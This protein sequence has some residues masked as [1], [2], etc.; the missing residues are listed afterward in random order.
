MRTQIGL[1]SKL[2]GALSIVNINIIAIA[3][4]SSERSI[5]V[6]VKNNVTTVG[7]QAIHRVLFDTNQ[8]IEIFIIGVGGVGSALI[9][10]I[11]RQYHWLK[12]N[13]SI[14]MKV[15]GIANSQGMYINT[16]G[17]NL[18][19]WKTLLQQTKMSCSLKKLL[20]MIK[21]NHLINPVIID[22]TSSVDIA[23]CYIDFLLNG[24]HV[25]TP[26][27]KA[28]TGSMQYYR[29]IRD[30]VVTSKKKFLYDTNVGAGL[31][32]I[33]NLQNLLNAGDE[34]ISFSGILSGSL[35]F[36]FGK[37][38]EG[39]SLSTATL[40]AKKKGYTEPNPKDDL[41]GIDVAR[42]LL[43]L[44][45][46]V[47]YE[48]ELNDIYIDTILSNDI[49]DNIISD[50]FFDQL[51][52]LD[53]MIFAKVK[54]ARSLGRVLRCIGSIQKG[55]CYVRVES[56]DNNHPLFTIKDGENALVFFTKYYQPLPLVLRGYGAGNDVTAAG[57][58]ADMLRILL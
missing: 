5:S 47:G 29:T 3:Q 26:N 56:I 55:Q 28:N 8:L 13:R 48:L 17:V 1:S 42:K 57:V 24:C 27:K 33:E 19:C 52:L 15:C 25:I 35:S 37:L 20:A 32:V 22:C 51:S 21:E 43:V 54:K 50:N 53:D 49:I 18:N 7:I 58:F 31:P 45:R 38:D 6:V 23:N 14:D 44:A 10:Q 36:I 40:L 16:N 9:E 39:L 12:K 2:F 46:E 30:T 41:S 34:L 4:G 11:R